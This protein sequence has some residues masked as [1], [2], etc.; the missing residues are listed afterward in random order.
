M[1]ELRLKT[2][3]T[4]HIASGEILSAHRCI[5]KCVAEQHDNEQYHL[6]YSSFSVSHYGFRVQ[7]RRA[8][9]T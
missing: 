8:Y 7:G 4:A 6:T 9:S 2:A 3:G 1:F 5:A